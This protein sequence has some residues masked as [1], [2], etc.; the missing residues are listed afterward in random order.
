MSAYGRN[1]TRLG[2]TC[3][4]S[5]AEEVYETIRRG[6]MPLKE[7]Q[8]GVVQIHSESFLLIALTD[9]EYSIRE[10]IRKMT[11]TLAGCLHFPLAKAVPPGKV[12]N[13][14]G[15]SFSPNATARGRL[16]STRN[17]RREF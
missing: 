4:L 17:R 10:D 5:I 7:I 6:E 15:L 8:V 16:E 14:P 13:I 1:L 9:Q 12:N 3:L 11:K 2:A